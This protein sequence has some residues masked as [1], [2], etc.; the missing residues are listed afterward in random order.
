MTSELPLPRTRLSPS[1]PATWMVLTFVEV[2][3]SNWVETHTDRLPVSSVRNSETDPRHE[4]S[5]TWG[6]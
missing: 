1:V 3:V 5:S 2:L 4:A 6:E